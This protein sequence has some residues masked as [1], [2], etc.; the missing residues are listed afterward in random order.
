MLARGCIRSVARNV[1][2]TVIAA[3][4][5]MSK[6]EKLVGSAGDGLLAALVR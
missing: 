3:I 6:G 4:G 5:M 2:G 1:H